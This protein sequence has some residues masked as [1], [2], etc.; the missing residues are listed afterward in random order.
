LTEVYSLILANS[1]A[2]STLLLFEV[3]TAFIYVGNKRNS[4][5]E[6]YMDGLIL[7]YFLIILIRILDRAVFHTSGA[8][9]AFL[10][11]DISGLFSQG[12][13]EISCFPLYT[14]NFSI[15]EDLYVG[16]PADLDQFGR[17]YSHGA[18]IGGIGLVKLSHLTANG[19]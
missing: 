16:M 14:V 3:K 1:F 13:F 4:L 2:N 19:R 15:G 18:V 12:Y 17:E 5:G 7:G 11:V 6:I 8:A 10:L 9:S